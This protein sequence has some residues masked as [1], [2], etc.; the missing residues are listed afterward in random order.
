M[1]EERDDQ[2]RPRLRCLMVELIDD[3]FAEHPAPTGDPNGDIACSLSLAPAL[4]PAQKPPDHLIKE[5]RLDRLRGNASVSFPV[6]GARG[7]RSPWP[8]S[9]WSGGLRPS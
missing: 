9:V 8:N 1:S 6:R 5:F 4:L 2:E 7:R 3:F